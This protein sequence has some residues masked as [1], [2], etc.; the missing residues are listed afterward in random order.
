MSG[1][2]WLLHCVACVLG[3]FTSDCQAAIDGGCV[4]PRE[5]WR[6][7]P[8]VIAELIVH[9]P[10]Y[11][12]SVLSGESAIK[13]PRSP[14][15]DITFDPDRLAALSAYNILDTPAEIGFDDIVKLAAHVCET[16]VALVSLVAGDRQWFKARVGFEPCETD[17]NSSVCAHALVE[18]DLLIIPDLSQDERTKSNPLV[19]GDPHIRFYAGAPLVASTGEPLGSLC[20]IDGTSRPQGLSEQQSEL[21]RALARQVM[22]QLE[23]RRRIEERDAAT[24]A[25]LAIEAL[26]RE[27][28]ALYRSLF[29]AID[30]G[31]CIIE[32]KFAD[33][34]A[35]D[36]RFVEINPAF[37]GHTGITDARGRWMRDIAPKHEQHWF[38]LYGQVALSKQPVRF[39]NSAHELGDRWFEAHAFPIDNQRPMLVG[40][41]FSDISHRKAIE[42]IR[43]EAEAMQHVLNQE[44]GHRMKNAFAM[45][46][47][48]ATQTLRGVSDR[49]PVDTFTR[50]IFAL[51]N[52]HD[53]LLGKSWTSARLEEV[54]TAAVSPLAHLD[55]FDLSGPAVDLGS[56]ATLSLSLLIHELTTNAIKY[57]SLSDDTGR[58][59]IVWG[60]ED[61]NGD[62][63]FTLGWKETGGPPVNEPT[64]LGFGSKLIRGGLL[65]SGGAEMRFDP[66]GLEVRLTAP[67]SELQLRPEGPFAPQNF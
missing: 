5:P 44:L 52:A 36:Y 3:N 63:N 51:S 42:T 20:V 66:S 31:F 28:T 4:N 24:A 11:D 54:V 7:A 1:G 62:V 56:R 32:M 22:T 21:L 37:E 64:G 39:E 57:G 35:V 29:D 53:I 41:L 46:L 30:V 17:L 16:P 38:D 45:V 15:P 34:A 40:I 55:R 12:R 23:L 6:R 48:I 59:S 10:T 43:Q 18:P 61:T 47:A 8:I 13:S 67:L 33:G 60:F 19:T 50:R 49:K 14:L 26:E 2:A 58:V 9:T 65:G 27:S 25:K